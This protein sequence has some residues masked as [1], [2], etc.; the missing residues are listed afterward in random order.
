MQLS[1]EALSVNLSTKKEQGKEGGSREEE[2][3]GRMPGSIIAW[4]VKQNDEKNLVMNNKNKS[5]MGARVDSHRFFV[6][7]TRLTLTLRIAG[8]Q[9]PRADTQLGTR[10]PGAWAEAQAKPRN[11]AFDSLDKQ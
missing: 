11:T 10:G 9:V 6:P 4:S 5:Q 3:E 7:G 2:K 1:G 8:A